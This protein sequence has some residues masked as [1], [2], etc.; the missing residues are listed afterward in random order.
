VTADDS[1]WSSLTVPDLRTRLSGLAH[2][3][4]KFGVI[5]A[6]A[7]VVDLGLYNQLRFGVGIGP[8]TSTAIATI[9]AMTVAYIGNRFWTWRNRSR[10]GVQ[11][12]YLMFA[13][14]NGAGLAIQLVCVGF[15]AY[16]LGLKD[17]QLAE[18][19]AKLIGIGL[20]TVFRFWAY[21]TWVFPQLPPADETDVALE[22]TTTTPY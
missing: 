10:H 11:R 13:I 1:D 6:L 15:A 19:V 16:A 12:E 2:E 20:G 18:N 9:V 14:V 3:V 21:R 5:G 22:R 17:H 4:A 7:F 8:L